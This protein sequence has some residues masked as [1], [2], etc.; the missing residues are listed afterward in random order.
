MAPASSKH[1]PHPPVQAD[2]I[3]FLHNKLNLNSLQDAAAFAAAAVCFGGQ[4]CLRKLLALLRQSILN[5]N[6]PIIS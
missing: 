2:M 1:P 3:E 5:P 6:L 4:W